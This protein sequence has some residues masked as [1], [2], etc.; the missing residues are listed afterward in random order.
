MQLRS[1]LFISTFSS[2]NFYVVCVC[3]LFV[4]S[5]FLIYYYFYCYYSCIAFIMMM[6][7]HFE[8]RCFLLTIVA[9]ISRW[10]WCNFQRGR[11]NF[12]LC[13]YAVDSN[14]QMHVVKDNIKS[15]C[16]SWRVQFAVY[17]LYDNRIYA[18]EKTMKHCTV[19]KEYNKNIFLKPNKNLFLI[20]WL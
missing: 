9:V 15:N 5:S 10:C 6:I 20:I 2:F 1:I 17:F 7:I 13:W 11:N 16:I 4:C 8:Y 19:H 12:E 14:G 3:V 18:T